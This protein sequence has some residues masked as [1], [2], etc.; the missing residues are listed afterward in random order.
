MVTIVDG[1]RLVRT[2]GSA[3]S[4]LTQPTHLAIL[5]FCLDQNFEPWCRGVLALYT[6]LLPKVGIVVET[7]TTR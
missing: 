5:V 7:T 3:Q 1:R 2:G 6:C 4:L